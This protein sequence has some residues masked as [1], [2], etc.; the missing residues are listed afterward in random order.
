MALIIRE[1]IEKDVEII[2]EFILALS[3]HQNLQQYVLTDAGTIAKHGFGQDRKFE[4]LLAEID[5]TPVGY[6]TYIWNY[7]TWAGGHYMF[8]EN[9][10]VLEQHRRLGVGVALMKEAKDICEENGCLNMKWEVESANENAIAFYKK[11]GGNITLRGI[12]SCAV[13]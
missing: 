3:S 1:A 2:S 8:I 13:K 5:G 4:T 10:F 6:L 7:S 11:I 12:G 9:I